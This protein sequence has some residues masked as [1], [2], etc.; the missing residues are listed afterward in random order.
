MRYMYYDAASVSKQFCI[1][2]VRINVTS[3]TVKLTQTAA[4]TTLNSNAVLMRDLGYV[5]HTVHGRGA[6]GA[7]LL[8]CDA[9]PCCE[10]SVVPADCDGNHGCRNTGRDVKHLHEQ[11]QFPLSF[12]FVCVQLFVLMVANTK[13]ANACWMFGS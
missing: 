5:H 11:R 6:V 1:F 10:Y 2:F 12:I 13:T 9:T 3:L 4:V 8:R 7:V